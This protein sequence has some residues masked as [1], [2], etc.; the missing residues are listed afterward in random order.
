M[1]Q[2]NLFNKI[3][4]E[5]P[6]KKKRDPFADKTERKKRK[7]TPVFHPPVSVARVNAAPNEGLTT[8]QVNERLEAGL[9]NKAP[10][11]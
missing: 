3:P 6:P 2:M 1:E 9:Y 7:K 5:K 4:D 8:E 10:K 11:K